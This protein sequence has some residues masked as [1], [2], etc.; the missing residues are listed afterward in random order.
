M[1]DTGPD[2]GIGPVAAEGGRLAFDVITE[3]GGPH[4]LRFR[5]GGANR[6]NV[7]AVPRVND[8]SNGT[9]YVLG[10]D[11]L[12]AA[13]IGGIAG[14]I[15]AVAGILSIPLLT[16]ISFQLGKVRALQLCMWLLVI[17]SLASWFLMTPKMPYLQLLLAPISTIGISG[18]W[19]F[20]SAMK[21]DIC[22]YD[23]YLN[24]NRRE[25]IFSAVSTWFQKL[26]LSFAYGIGPGFLLVLI[27]FD[28]GFGGQQPENTVLYMR[29]A[30]AVIPAALGMLGIV[31]LLLYELTDERVAEIRSLL[32]ERRGEV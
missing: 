2:G 12:E 16:G 29:I 30:F 26:T 28:E 20:V 18:F 31:A 15:G 22:D 27:G 7:A 23:E 9:Y 17:N 8:D 24:G 19:L 25:G 13:K 6:D 10:G 11:T 3:T 32:I 4:L 14:T 21:A 1:E 5:Y